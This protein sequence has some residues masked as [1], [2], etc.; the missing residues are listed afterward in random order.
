MRKRILSFLCALLLCFGTAGR[1]LADSAL[2]T[3]RLCRLT[4][5]YSR[6]ESCFADLNIDLYRV[7]GLTADGEMELLEPYS[8]YPIDI[9]GITSQQQ[10]LDIAQTVRSFV[11]AESLAPTQSRTTD[12]QGNA[13]FEDLETGLYLV[14]GILTRDS[15]GAVFF[16]DFMIYLPAPTEGG[17]NYDIQA[18]PKFTEYQPTTRY[19][20]VKLWKDEQISDQRP[21][22]VEV[23]IFRDGV[24]QETV[25]LNPK[26][27]WSYSWVTED[28]GALWSVMERN[29][30]DNYRIAIEKDET[31]FV[32]TNTALSDKP[33]PPSTGDTSPLLMYVLLLCGSGFAMLLLGGLWLRD[34]KR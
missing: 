34:R 25:Y 21:K 8:G 26:N 29:V 33:T 7:A 19:T 27:N 31:V 4:L 22:S 12:A 15:E 30:P 10:W 3:Q 28:D 16:Y 1:A 20:V 23:E 17:Y 5:T 9:T 18:K 13:V 6:G 14:K 11:E 32:I 2:D 24:S